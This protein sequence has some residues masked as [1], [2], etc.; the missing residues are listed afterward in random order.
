MAKDSCGCLVDAP[1]RSGCALSIKSDSEV[2]YAN[3]YGVDELVEQKHQ[4]VNK[5]VVLNGT[6][7]KYEIGPGIM[8]WPLKLTIRGERWQIVATCVI[9][10]FAGD[11]H[12]LKPHLDAHMGRVIGAKV[13]ANNY[14]LVAVKCGDHEFTVKQ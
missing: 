9:G 3:A 6:L 14:A 1:H 4:F 5:V 8:T 10:R 12:T 7:V 11:H 13:L 2:G